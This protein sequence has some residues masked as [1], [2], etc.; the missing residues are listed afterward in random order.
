MGYEDS[1]ACKIMATHCCACGKPLV[2]AKSVET[3]MGPVC[4]SKYGFDTEVPERVRTLA[5]QIVYRLACDVSHGT[6]TM[7]SM[8]ASSQLRALGFSKIADIFEFRMVKIAVEIGEF[9]GQEC[10]FLRVPYDESGKFNYDAWTKTRFKVK[11][12]AFK[13][14]T[15]K[16]VFHWGYAK[17]EYARKR[18]FSALLKHHEGRLA[19]A[20][21]GSVFEI[22]PLKTAAQKAAEAAKK[23]A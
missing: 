20:P 21:D 1:T 12:P 4:R 14:P 2:D 3:G 15:Q 19:F 23:A 13:A 7:E 6:V 18:I 11:R 16:E 10:Y 8:N 17:D 22:K 9:D 5:N